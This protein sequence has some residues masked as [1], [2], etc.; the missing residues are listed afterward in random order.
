MRFLFFL[1]YL[2]G[3]LLTSCADNPLPAAEDQE[4]TVKPKPPVTEEE[5]EEE[6]E[7]VLPQLHVVGR[8]LRN[9][10]GE[11]INLHGFAQTYSPFFNQNAWN[12]YDVTGCLRY[13]Q[14]LINGILSAGW[15][16]NFVR[17]H[18]DPYWSDD[19]SMP[20]VRYEGHERFSTARFKKYLDEVFIPMAKFANDKGLYVVFR[21][22][23]V[24]PEKI[25]VGDDYNLFLE[26]VWSIVS[27]HPKIKNNHGIMFE[28][29]NEPINILGPDGTYASSGQGHF[30]RMKLFCQRI[31]DK[32]RANA[33]NIIWVPGL[34]YQSS[35]SGFANNPVEGN[36]IGYA[37]HA[38]P[39][40]Y[41]SD[42]E[43]AS[44][45]LGGTMG[46]GYESFQQGWNRQVKPVADFAPVMVTEMDW[47]PAKYDASWGK[48]F[49][50]TVGGPGFGANFKYIADMTGNVSWLLFTECHRLAAFNNSP[51]TPG[52]YSFLNDP[53]ACPWPIYH[54]FTEYANQNSASASALEKLE[55]VGVDDE[56][57]ILTGGERYL[58]TRAIFADGSIRHVTAETRFQV[59]DESILRIEENGIMYALRDG[60]AVVTATY[61]SPGGDTREAVVNVLATTFPLTTEMFNPSIF[62]EGSFD[63]ETKTLITG[64]WGF[65]G[66]WYNKGVDLSSYQYLIAELGNDNESGV[67]FRLFDENN[68]WSQPARYDFGNESRV[69]VDLHNMYK[70]VGDQQVKLD[71]SH[72]YIIGFWSSGNKPIVIKNV[73]LT[74]KTS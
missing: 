63:E 36:N 6:Q 14:M 52:Q 56:L 47:A 72:I 2:C 5:N 31:V 3:L 32:I 62:E 13:N 11:T 21:P 53:E 24:S 69:V 23:G 74:D 44:P 66:W 29:A 17:M 64:Q 54:W 45:E 40:W 43:E 15:K 33:D 34:A 12:N 71:P 22:P 30:D 61:T 51:G 7:S 37:V 50:G 68:Y 70:Q 65:G 26:E 39:G 35:F 8:T 16:M 60:A 58:I 25:A 38:Y 41:G 48:S 1:F 73:Y 18:M 67:S 27:S 10:A 57:P 19:P 59:S 49:T 46:G 55:I 20:S 9:D 42:T 4:E 28:L